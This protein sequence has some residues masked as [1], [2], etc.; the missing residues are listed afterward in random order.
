MEQQAK[1]LAEIPSVLIGTP[2]RLLELNNSK[3]IDLTRLQTLIIDEFDR[4]IPPLGKYAN[5][6][7]RFNRKVHPLP[8]ELFIDEV[9]KLKKQYAT[10]KRG[11]GVFVDE[12]MR[13]RLQ[14]LVSSATIN[15]RTRGF[16]KGK[17]WMTNPV[18]LDMNCSTIA[19]IKHYGY[20]IDERQQCA[21]ITQSES[22][23]LDQ[24]ED[25][26]K[27]LEV[28]AE[29]IANLYR[30]HAAK[31]AFVFLPSDLSVGE[32]VRLLQI[33]GL[34]AARLFEMNDFHRKST[35]FKSLV[36]GSV[37]VVCAT[38]M[39]ARGLDVPGIDT[40]FILGSSDPQSYVHTSG[41]TGRFGAAGK[42]ITILPTASRISKYLQNLKQLEIPLSTQL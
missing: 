26:F 14:V 28:V 5:V 41:R 18:I 12:A 2:N 37:N 17:N 39:E 19:N 40:V 32:M 31:K 1:D 21:Q 30:S 24:N 8:A 33:V 9:V 29:I 4:M 15:N 27:D 3:S 10:P 38:E 7:K 23:I 22:E 36:D 35:P 16:L 42:A 20:Y 25:G 34:K 13:K 11:G 6:K